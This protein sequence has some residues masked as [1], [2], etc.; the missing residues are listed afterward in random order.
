MRRAIKNITS[1]PCCGVP[2][3]RS[4]RGITSQAWFSQLPVHIG[5]SGDMQVRQQV[6][7]HGSGSA[8]G[9]P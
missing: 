7:W 3:G 8:L 4:Q 9:R 5:L 2:R 1:Q 6:L